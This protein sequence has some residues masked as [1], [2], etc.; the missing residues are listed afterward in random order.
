[1]KSGSAGQSLVCVSSACSPLLRV[2]I[3]CCLRRD[4]RGCPAASSLWATVCVSRE[5]CATSAAWVG[6]CC[7]LA[8][9]AMGRP[10]ERGGP[11]GHRR[12]GRVDVVACTTHALVRA[13][14]GIPHAPCRYPS[15][16]RIV[17][18]WPGWCP[19]NPREQQCGVLTPT[20]GCGGDGT[21]L[22]RGRDPC[23]ARSGGVVNVSDSGARARAWMRR[24]VVIHR[25]R[26]RTSVR[27]GVGQSHSP[28]HFAAF[29]NPA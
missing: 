17:P 29:S 19:M 9:Y 26:S 16:P 12:I 1:M 20:G 15:G 21:M 28:T 24:V 22:L 10:M 14:C 13:T 23:D 3:V 7:R 4:G 27:C 6:C 18:R 25:P 5:T 2:V 8:V 11:G